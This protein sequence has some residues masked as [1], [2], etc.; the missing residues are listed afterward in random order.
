MTEE[1]F[2]LRSLREVVNI[3]T[4]GSGQASFNLEIQDGVADLKLGFQLGKPSDPHPIP[5]CSD[6]VHPQPHHVDLPHEH[7]GF[8][9]R[10]H[11]RRHKG[12]KQHERDRA[13]AA[14]HQASCQPATTAVPAVTLPF[15]GKL[16][17][18]IPTVQSDP[19]VT[20]PVST[21]SFTSSTDVSCRPMK[22]SLIFKNYV[23]VSVVKKQL[24]GSQHLSPQQT[25]PPP[26]VRPLVAPT[27]AART[28]ATSPTAARPPA[29][30]PTAALPPQKNYQQ[31]EDQL[32]TRLFKT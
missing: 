17:S 6:Y 11:P 12:P 19:A 30:P 27:T 14:K 8:Q 20:V 7:A 15:V 21:P 5:M 32:W 24:F 10:K 1:S 26:A 13:R 2:I 28:P 3:W 25:T 23:D 31:M 29:A 9:H 16:L 22:S 18:V 4:R